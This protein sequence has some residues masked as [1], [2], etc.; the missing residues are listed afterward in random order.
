MSK[1]VVLV[2][3]HHQELVELH[4]LMSFQGRA[5]AGPAQPLQVDAQALRELQ[6]QKPEGLSVG[7]GPAR[8]LESGPD[9]VCGVGSPSLVLT[10]SRKWSSGV[11]P[12]PH[13]TSLWLRS[14]IKETTSIC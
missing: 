5:V 4:M 10:A 6:G 12:F 2:D 14:G 8:G 3:V 11:P 13:S 9:K 7:S 1:E